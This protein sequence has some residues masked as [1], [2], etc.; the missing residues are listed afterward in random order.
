MRRISVQEPKVNRDF[1]V[2]LQVVYT[3]AVY[4]YHVTL[5]EEDDHK[6]LW[7]R[8][9]YAILCAYDAAECDDVLSDSLDREMES[10]IVAVFEG[11]LENV[12][13]ATLRLT[14]HEDCNGS[15]GNSCHETTGL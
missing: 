14:G 2:I 8:A 10:Q 9:E 5:D 13:S 6:P 4:V 3:S 11:C 15:C 12:R 1:T 7:Q